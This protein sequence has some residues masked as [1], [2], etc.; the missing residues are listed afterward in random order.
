MGSIRDRETSRI[1]E[2]S[3]HGALRN[4]KW[5]GTRGREVS[6]PRHNQLCSRGCMENKESYIYLWKQIV[7]FDKI[8]LVMAKYFTWLVGDYLIC[9]ACACAVGGLYWFVYERG[10]VDL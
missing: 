10:R 4:R 2:K 6:R 8:D 9:F 1:Y 7:L 5:N 3:V